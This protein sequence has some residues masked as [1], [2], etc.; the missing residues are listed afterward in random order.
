MAASFDF[1][2]DPFQNFLDLF[3]QAKKEIPKDPN[4]M[5][6][7]TSTSSGT[8]SV[9]TVLFKGLVRGGFS[10]YTNYESQKS[11]E[12]MATG[13]AAL[14]FYWPPMDLQIRIEGLVEKL[15]AEESANYFKTRPRLSQ[16]GAWSSYQS[17]K[18]SS[19]EEIEKRVTEYENKF[20]NQEV[21]CPPF[22]GGFHVLPLT[23]EFWF[24]RQGRLH[25]RYIYQ[26]PDLSAP[27]QTSMKAP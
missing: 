15:T 8:P 12:L 19:H 13:K 27:W 24:A 20:V 23:I 16:L 26:R 6:L 21:P 11:K 22:W 10:F 7:A 3:E 4:A 1:S 25:D 18:I 14:L 17:Q 9:R 5:S 2:R